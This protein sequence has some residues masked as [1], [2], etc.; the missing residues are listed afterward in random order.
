MIKQVVTSTFNS[1][2]LDKLV[3]N[4]YPKEYWAT[5]PLTLSFHDDINGDKTAT[6]NMVKMIKE[7]NKDL[8]VVGFLTKIELYMSNNITDKLT[9]L[10]ID[11]VFFGV[12]FSRQLPDGSYASDL[13]SPSIIKKVTF[14]E[15]AYDTT[16]AIQNQ[17]GDSSD[18][19]AG[20]TGRDEIDFNEQVKDVVL[21]MWYG[22]DLDN[23][24]IASA[25]SVTPDDLDNLNATIKITQEA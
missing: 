6:Y 1:F 12:C 16:V 8:S 17:L 25:I 5:E 20:Y 24:P 23:T 21:L 14:T 11:A 4:S 19:L 2:G 3:V 15:L 7:V 10:G 9:L 13:D 18:I 22:V